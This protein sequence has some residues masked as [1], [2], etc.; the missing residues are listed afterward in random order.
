MLYDIAQLLHI[1]SEKLL[2][3]KPNLQSY[4]DNNMI[5]PRVLLLDVKVFVHLFIYLFIF[6]VCLFLLFSK[7]TMQSRCQVKKKV[8]KMNENTLLLYISQSK[9]NQKN[10]VRC[11]TGHYVAPPMASN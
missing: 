5:L 8:S 7:N 6:F 9:T 1:L 3:N 11:P 2:I 10:C 4:I